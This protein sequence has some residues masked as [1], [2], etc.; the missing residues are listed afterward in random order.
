MG[1]LFGPLLADGRKGNS[2]RMAEV[3]PALLNNQ[4]IVFDF[5]GV[6]NMTDSF[7]NGCFATLIRRHA[8]E[9]EGR[10]KFRNCSA[11]IRDFLTTALAR[12]Y[13]E[14][15]QDREPDRAD[16]DQSISARVSG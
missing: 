13:R 3:E 2:F 4:T 1:R 10:L 5:S 11:L 9:T 15:S 7:A 12:G 6:E 16:D 14:A 8:H